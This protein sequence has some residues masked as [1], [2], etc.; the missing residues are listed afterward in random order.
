VETVTDAA[1]VYEIIIDGRLD[2]RWSEWFDG[3][4]LSAIGLSA[5]RLRGA[6]ADQAALFGVLKKIHNLGLVLVSVK[7]VENT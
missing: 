5:T 2:S 4:V 6:L 3:M 1:T 7:R